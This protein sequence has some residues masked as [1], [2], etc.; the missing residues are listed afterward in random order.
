MFA[1]LSVILLPKNLKLN[2]VMAK[3]TVPGCCVSLDTIV[4]LTYKKVFLISTTIFPL[5]TQVWKPWRCFQL[6]PSELSLISTCKFSLLV[7]TVFIHFYST[8]WENLTIT[9]RLSCIIITYSVFISLSNV[10]GEVP[11][12]MWGILFTSWVKKNNK[13]RMPRNEELTDPF[14]HED[15]N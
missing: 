6:Q 8:I 4:M 1:N 5:T 14:T 10:L 2:L 7:C 15:P 11:A 3:P 9:V 13:F 12:T